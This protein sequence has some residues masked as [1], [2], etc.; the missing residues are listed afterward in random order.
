MKDALHSKDGVVQGNILASLLNYCG[1]NQG[2]GEE[3]GSPCGRY[4]VSA[5]ENY[6]KGWETRRR[7]SVITVPQ[8]LAGDR[9][10]NALPPFLRYDRS[11]KVATQLPAP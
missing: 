11:K 10:T 7:R 5:R 4:G 3:S 9:H 1:D 2:A 6:E 8:A